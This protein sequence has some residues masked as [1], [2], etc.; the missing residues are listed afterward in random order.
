MDRL[1]ILFFVFI[2]GVVL[3]TFARGYSE[4]IAPFIRR[5]LHFSYE[6][7]ILVLWAILL[8]T[9]FFFEFVVIRLLL[10]P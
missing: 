2:S 8:L 3:L 4:T 5:R 6:I 9:A 10:E 1:G 7:E